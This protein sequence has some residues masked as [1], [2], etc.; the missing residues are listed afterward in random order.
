MYSWR[1]LCNGEYSRELGQKSSE[2]DL[3]QTKVIR[4]GKDERHHFS[5]SW[6]SGIW[7]L[8][9]VCLDPVVRIQECASVQALLLNMI[10]LSP[11]PDSDCSS[12]PSQ[13]G[14]SYVGK[15]MPV[16]VFPGTP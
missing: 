16:F 8:K 15:A 13:D 9:R 5:G 14:F 10:R 7:V 2:G 11:E 1:R 4:A 6:S 3:V 12:I